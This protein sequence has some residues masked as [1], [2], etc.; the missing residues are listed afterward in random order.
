MTRS[1]KSFSCSGSGSDF[2][3]SRYFQNAG[4]RSV[5]EQGEAGGGAARARDRI[6]AAIIGFSYVGGR[7]EFEPGSPRRHASYSLSPAAAG[8]RVGVRGSHISGRS[9][10]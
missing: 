7:D 9:E 6:V 1:S 10:E 4:M 8:E 5:A 2:A 3:S